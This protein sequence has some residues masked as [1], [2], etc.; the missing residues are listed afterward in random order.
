MDAKTA[1]DWGGQ[2]QVGKILKKV[3]LLEDEPILLKLMEDELKHH[4]LDVYSFSDP[5]EL[6][7]SVGPKELSEQVL[8]TDE[9]MH[10]MS[11]LSLVQDLA[12]ELGEKKPLCI[13]FTGDSDA[14]EDH[15]GRD[16]A[17]L[18]VEKPID[19]EEF[20]ALLKGMISI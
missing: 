15:P 6:L 3:F 19:P 9:R 5:K 14:V 20:I 17:D 2:K 4:D 13:I 1:K 8:I 16:L 18:V 11:G 10:G 12:Q 7:D